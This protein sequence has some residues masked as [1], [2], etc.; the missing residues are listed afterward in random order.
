MAFFHGLVLDWRKE[1]RQGSSRLRRRTC[2]GFWRNPVVNLSD[3]D[4]DAGRARISAELIAAAQS[5]GFFHLEGHGISETLGA[6][7]FAASRAFFA[8]SDE[9]NTIGNTGKTQG[10]IRVS[11]PAKLANTNSR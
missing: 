6:R 7:A 2:G 11:R 9:T 1:A 8:L 10:L 5:S 4:S 3:L